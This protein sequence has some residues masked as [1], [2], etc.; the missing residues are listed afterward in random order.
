MSRSIG[1]VP[2]KVIGRP[3]GLRTACVSTAMALVFGLASAAQA[4][5]TSYAVVPNLGDGSLSLIDTTAGALFL[6]P[7]V[8]G[9]PSCVAVAP[10][11]RRAYVAAGAAGVALLDMSSGIVTP[12]IPTTGAVVCVAITPDG[13]KAY[14]TD[15][16]LNTVTSID[17]SNNVAGPAIPVGLEP[18]GIAI[19]PN[20][21]RVYVTNLGS[22]SVSVIDTATD[23]VVGTIALT[24]VAPFGIVIAP[25]GQTAYVANAGSD[26]VSVIDLALGAE[27]LPAIPVGVE[28]LMLAVTPEGTTLYV[29]N[30]AD[31]TVSVIDTATKT[32]T[33]T[34]V[35]PPGRPQGLAITPDGHTVYV[36][37]SLGSAVQRI[38]VATNTLLPTA[39]AVGT[40]PLSF[41]SFMSPNYI[42]GT[43]GPLTIASDA[44]L[45]AAAFGTSYVDFAGG[46]LR[47]G[48]AWSTNRTVSV[49][50]SGATLDTNGFDA[51]LT[52]T[53]VGEGI[54][55]K[56]GNGTLI[57]T[58]A[59]SATHAGGTWVNGG[60]LEVDGAHVTDIRLFGGTLTGTGVAGNV[61][62]VGGTIRPGNAVPGTLQAANVTLDSMML[63]VRLNGP[64]AGI[65]YDVLQVTGTATLD[66]AQLFPS[67]GYTPATGDTFTIVTNATGTF[68]GYPEGT[69]FFVNDTYL[70][71]TYHGGSSGHD[72]VLA[73]DG[74]PTISSLPILTVEAGATIPP[75]PFTVADDFTDPSALVI[76]VDS[77]D[78]SLVP[79]SN[80]VIGG[81]GSARTLNVT[82]VPGIVGQ[83][84]I[85]VIV[86]DG[87]HVVTQAASVVTTPATI[88]Y[89]LAE[90]ATGSFFSTDILIAN[91]NNT[92]TPIKLTFYK[93]DGSTIEQPYLMDPLSHFTI[94]ANVYPGLES[95]G[96]STSVAS[97]SGAPLAVERTMWWDATHY[98]AHGEKASAG[99]ALQ[100][101]FAE[102]SQG[103]FHTYFLLLNPGALANVAHVTYFLEDGSPLQKDYA[104]A[105]T[106]RTTV[107]IASE[108][109]L[110]NRSFGALVTFDRPGMA[111]RAMYFGD[112]PLFTG[113]HD[114]SGA[115]APCT[116]WFLAEG[117]TGS[118]FDTFVL[119]ANPND[120]PATVTTTYLPASGLAV[121][122]PH[123]VAAHQRLTINIAD[124]DPTL[125]SAAVGTTV[126]A[127]RPV[128]VERSQYW[129]HGN[130]HEA[131]NSAGET[132][133]GTKWALAE[134]RV[135]GPDHAQTYILLANS[136]TQPAAVMATFLREHGTPP[137]VKTFTVAPTSRLNIAVTGPGSDV[138]EL[139]DENF[140]TSLISTQPIIIERSMYTDANGVTWAAGT[141]ATATRLP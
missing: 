98:G 108:P 114:S 119:I 23:T 5:V 88:T 97:P 83:T 52:H 132:S 78:Q 131:H 135:G 33:T 103:Y 134:G 28:P 55:N 115:T 107:D 125:A 56:T 25:N 90:G 79:L 9:S 62:G 141:N 61:T 64:T 104:L 84:V 110:A 85:T 57:V 1:E 86:S 76:N 99:P 58:G 54:L 60:T 71:I 74:P 50:L 137:L 30:A 124:E 8:G 82:L 46:T 129:P 41:A 45:T 19:A 14:F 69:S 49:L 94:P 89:Y 48:D 40:T 68:A 32:V 24:A 75:I 118:F 130:W 34:V 29:A 22:N 3:G 35:L 123:V 101:Y 16:V 20:G 80:I 102:G 26:N 81:S 47:L 39:I 27:T 10:D 4:Q 139:A 121:A 31:H 17:R 7:S 140:G 126:T 100:W 53:I 91:P 66:N 112:S 109:A 113:G 37:D 18:Q 73:V 117:A 87:H 59:A 13:R 106:S 96:F 63:N 105:A 120:Q 42:V 21:Q 116:S 136:G 122:K 127:D 11:G 133:A 6:S 12:I 111:E 44:D 92:L 36:L 43:G 138:P 72:V 65:G 38:D 67:L 2:A 77:S 15:V 128:I 95:A 93:D 70:H 51:T